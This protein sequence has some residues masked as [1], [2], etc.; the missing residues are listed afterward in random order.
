MPKNTNIIVGLE[1]GTSKI[2]TAVGEV[3]ER[4]AVAII[5]LGQSRSD[6]VRKGEIVDFERAADA[7]RVALAEAEQTSNVE[8]RS[9]YLGVSGAHIQAFTSHGFHPI[10]TADRQITEEDVQEVLRN[11]KTVNLPEGNIV[12]HAIRQNFSVDGNADVR[13]P[14]GLLGR[15]LE[16]DVLVVHGMQTRLQNPIKLLKEELLLN[17]EH[18]VFNGIAASLATLDAEQKELGTLVIDLGGGTTDYVAVVDGLIK[19]CGVIAVGG[20]HISN[21]LAVG[22]KVPL[23]RAEKLKTEYGSAI[24]PNE[25]KGKFI[26][27]QNELGL[28][29]KNINLENLHLIMSARLE[30]LFEIIYHDLEE[31]GILDD[32]R[33]GIVICGGGARIP[34]IT[35]LAERIFQLPTV[36]GTPKGFGGISSSLNKPEFATALG[37]IKFGCFRK[38]TTSKN[39]GFKELI[40][41]AISGIFPMRN[42]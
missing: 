16:V 34:R 20:D 19:H 21:D 36:V 8:I 31:H 11:A 32:L 2:C 40:R 25:V 1:I 30:E 14:V 26:S 5:G 42:Q 38:K 10:P 13:N 35:E 29:A 24:V 7:I 27:I 15:K 41:S 18:T 28:P 12:I 23:G 33:G 9:V 39:S 17:V 37:L 4:G 3:D 6:G 22:L